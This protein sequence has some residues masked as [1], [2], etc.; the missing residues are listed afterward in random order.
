VFLKK[1]KSS[2]SKL[3]ALLLI[4]SGLV[5]VSAQPASA[6]Y[7]PN[8]TLET[9]INFDSAVDGDFTGFGNA[10]AEAQ[11]S[12]SPSV[13]A[14]SSVSAG[15]PATGK[16]VV[17]NRYW[18]T[19]GGTNFPV[20][21]DD[22][23][24]SAAGKV[25]KIRIFTP[26]AGMVVKLQMGAPGNNSTN[27]EVD[28][29]SQAGWQ[30]ATFDFNSLTSG[31]YNES[32]D[33]SRA[34]IFFNFGVGEYAGFGPG[35]GEGGP[36]YFDNVTYT[37]TTKT[38]INFD[39]AVDNDFSGFG[40]AY[41]L[42]QTSVSPSVSAVASVSAGAPT[43]GK[44][45]VVNR[46]WETYGGTNLPVLT[47][48]EYISSGDKVVKIRIFTPRAGMV[49][50]L[51]MGAPGN[52]STN[53][54]VDVDS[55]AGWQV[56]T[57]DFN[58]LT[59]G[60][61][62]ESVDYS[63]ATIFF[64]FGVGE[65]AGFGPGDGEGGP[66]YFDDVTYTSTA[67]GGGGGSEVQLVT[68]LSQAVQYA[69]ESRPSGWETFA[70]A[71]A[72][73]V[74]TP[75]GANAPS[76]TN[77]GYITESDVAGV[78]TYA[79][80]TVDVRA[81]SELISATSKIVQLRVKAPTATTSVTMKLEAPGND[82][83]GSTPTLYVQKSA[84]A[85]TTSWQVLTFDFASPSSGTYTEGSAYNKIV[86][87]FN[88]GTKDPI[89]QTLYFDD[90][91]FTPN[92]V[93]LS[94]STPPRTG[95]N[96]GNYPHIRLDKSFLDT[97]VDATWWD[98]VWQYRDE[99]TRAYLKY[100][101]VR[102]TFKLTYTVT[103]KNDEP[104]ADA[105]VTL[106][107]NANYSC[108]KTF[109]LY[110]NS[111]IGPDDCAGNGETQLPAKRTDADGKVT[112]VLTNTNS[113]GEKMPASLNGTPN[114]KEIGTN[115][116]PHLVGATKEGIDMLFAHFVEQSDAAKVVTLATETVKTGVPYAANFQ[117]LDEAGK[118]MANQL[119]EVYINGVQS[120]QD[121]VLT[122][123]QGRVAIPVPNSENVEGTSAVAVSVKR[124]GRLPL[125]GTS[126]ITWV[127][128]ALKVSMAPASNSVEVKIVNAANESVKIVINGKSY[129]RT[130]ATG[131]VTYKFPAT[132]GKKVIRVTIGKKT[133]VKSVTVKK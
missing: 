62:N 110:E 22:E 32:V 82:P 28:I 6:T 103:D 87:F 99:D 45:V 107:V 13:S 53:V 85:G 80:L 106:I 102:S 118:P 35:D 92:A 77:S 89:T 17:V 46:Y 3:L 57:F 67:G 78:E 123:A 41:A 71:S 63:R 69:F 56:A 120:K 36:F 93:D 84:T 20:L 2:V 116:K 73:V 94:T 104:M 29:N 4:S 11:T 15:A 68:T 124:T 40:N 37:S 95:E 75:A 117:F 81:S 10:Y 59:S 1:S 26:R 58:S 30:I 5:A 19:Y 64:N 39:S 61:Y 121:W 51:Q 14:V 100:I 101:P 25:V 23:Y 76:G 16:F 109:F 88:L 74:A 132:L 125:T 12:V 7:V 86:L 112:F 128:G 8:E 129:E 90:L 127:P 65:Y 66:F 130:P 44:F 119:A 50:K 21:A 27:V 31:S 70:G 54:E 113:E 126:M 111:I 55:E 48:D 43:T 24:I 52:N 18:E 97:N 131:L 133:F 33:Y 122:D 98:G 115:I 105:L 108:A 49:V 91:A 79:G 60:S 96:K 38:V 42:V 83:N 72:G 9:V 47:G 34:T 114:G